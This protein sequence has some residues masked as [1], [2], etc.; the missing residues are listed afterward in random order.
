MKPQSRP[1]W[2]A[3]R[4][5]TI[6]IPEAASAASLLIE[7]YM[8]ITI[9][10]VSVEK[11]SL[12]LKTPFITA[13]RR[14][15]S[16]SY[17]V[18]RVYTD[19]NLVGTGG[20]SPTPVITGDTEGSIE[21]AVR[22][23]Y[24]PLLIGRE[25]TPELLPFIQKAI[26]RNTSPKAA[27]DI[28]VYDLLSKE[29]GMN[30]ETYLG[31]GAGYV[32]SDITI[33]IGD[34]DKVAYDIFAAI[35]D[36]FRYLKIKLGR[37]FDEDIECIR[38][39]ADIVP[40]S[41]TVRFDANQAWSR[42]DAVK[43]INTASETGLNIDLFEQPLDARDIDGMAYV[44][45]N[46]SI[47]ILAD[48]SIFDYYDAKRVIDA[49]AANLINIKLMKC[50]GIFEAEK[51]FALAKASGLEC[52]MGCMMEGPESVAAAAIF[53]SARNI[54]RCDLDAVFLCSYIPHCGGAKFEK[55]KIIF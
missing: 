21:Y 2:K 11:K 24:R 45:Q 12:P 53:A 4:I 3:L 38:M 40:S 18:V 16:L 6:F 13:K 37:G 19:S 29:Q 8:G 43:I 10:D 31:T 35:D 20:C 15:D 42:E 36:G 34:R 5:K 1:P 30:L 52:M 46:T 25:V 7:E 22:E 23:Y 32:E 27:I 51:I 44:T 47:P 41:I 28:A 50:G 9:T 17:Y 14:L 55:G 39:I 54:T 33:S 48:E 26:F 49:G